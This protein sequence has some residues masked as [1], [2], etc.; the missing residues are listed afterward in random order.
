MMTDEFKKLLAMLISYNIPFYFSPPTI[1]GGGYVFGY[2]IK[3]GEQIRIW[4]W[5][6]ETIY[7]KTSTFY[8]DPQYN[9]KGLD[10]VRAEVAIH[11]ILDREYTENGVDYSE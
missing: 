2:V 7:D 1:Y 4:E 10:N 11:F 5:D 6:D 8:S 3:D 9:D